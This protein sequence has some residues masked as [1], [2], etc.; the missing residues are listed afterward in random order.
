[1]ADTNNTIQTTVILNTG[2]AEQQIVKLNGVASDSTKSLKER[3]DA[4]NKAVELSNRLSDQKVKKLKKEIK[5]LTGVRGSEKKLERATKA[6]N[7]EQLKQARVTAQNTKAQ[8]RLSNAYKRGSKSS[9]GFLR[10]L[11]GAAGGIGIVGA[12]AGVAYLAVAALRNVFNDI[13]GRIVSFDKTMVELSAILGENR[14]EMVDL[15]GT[16]RNVAA[17]SIKTS[18]EVGALA[19]TLVTLG[20]SKKEV[21][22]LLKPTNDL[23]IALKASSDAAG[24][25]LVTTLNAF[26]RGTDEAEHFANV[27][28]K[29]RT[30]TA[31]DFERIKISLGFLA[32]VASSV[33]LEFEKT[34]AI[35]G[36]LVDNGIRASRAG[37][38]MGTAFARLGAKGLTYDD[39]LNQINASNDK[40]VTSTKLL[41]AQ[42]GAL[43]VIL[44]RDKQKVE[45][46]AVELT[47][48][49]GVLKRLTDKQLESTAAKFKILDSAWEAFI[50]RLD[51]GR[52]V[53]SNIGKGFAVFAT[54]IL[55]SITPVDDLAASMED[56]RIELL[57][58][59][60]KLDEATTSEEERLAIILQLKRE[61]PDFLGSIDAETIS[62]EA[63]FK[64]IKDINKSLINKIILQRK[65]QEI[66]EQNEDVATR[67]LKQIKAKDKLRRTFVK[68][69]EDTNL[70]FKEGLTLEEKVIKLSEAS[71]SAT[72]EYSREIRKLHF[73]LFRYQEAVKRL[74]SEEGE[75]IKL[76]EERIKLLEELDIKIVDTTEADE[77]LAAAKKLALE[78]QK[79]DDLKRATA[80]R[81]RVKDEKANRA[82]AAV[83][84]KKEAERNKEKAESSKVVGSKVKEESGALKQKQAE[85]E[86]L[87]NAELDRLLAERALKLEQENLTQEQKSQIEL[88][89]ADRRGEVRAEYNSQAYDDEL[90]SLEATRALKLEQLFLEQEEKDVIEA[91]YKAKKA[92]IELQEQERIAE[93]K[94]AN[95]DAEIEQFE[96]EIEERRRR[97]EVVLELELELLNMKREQELSNTELTREEILA[98]N[99]KYDELEKKLKFTTINAI[100]ESDKL[101]MK[102]GIALAAEALGIEKELAI[103]KM[104][105]AAPKAVGNVWEVAAT[106]KT[107][108]QM[109]L[110]GVVGTATV[111]A[112]IIKG[113]SDIKKVRFPGSKGKGESGTISA[114]GG[115]GGA[116]APATASTDIIS[117]VETNNSARQ[118][119]NQ[120]L[121][122]SAT[123]TAAGR[124][125]GGVGNVIF[126]EASYRDF[127]NQVDFK[128]HKVI[129]G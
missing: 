114:S 31:L 49:D 96:I 43:G 128:E 71:R 52:G 34:G 121:G 3:I 83:E 17:G 76:T 63:L 74:N 18:N 99:K 30:T 54:G 85:A 14:R 75:S 33:G 110:H 106:K 98:I 36:V 125:A 9:G 100:F 50:L 79:A 67:L 6:L 29:M 93:D 65:D 59:T 82:K 62:N 84:K 120:Q 23:S 51:D 95:K 109:I 90:A 28:A 40:L 58:L 116:A 15:E 66:A 13:T 73:D 20:K 102:A 5:S 92:E 111:L 91:E 101:A 7:K 81:Q 119:V 129:I 24:E 88:D 44:A 37:R 1:M 38:L 11:K 8:N 41:G 32:P 78:E 70:K 68:A 46:L 103:A 69:L 2:Q 124:I 117:S 22:T 42:A 77:E 4:K 72:G 56:Q 26:G 105:M 127:Q 19:R 108:P 97:G 113:L 60:S 25:L 57:M 64:S 87:Y 21:K 107:L 45:D 94:I 39:A 123:S 47:N 27:I 16:I 115:G 53:L 35:L 112:P 12:T 118:G 48:V 122:A 10:S 104:L 80:E 126:S 86:I 61:Y 89:F 55:R